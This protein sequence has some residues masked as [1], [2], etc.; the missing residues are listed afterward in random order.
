[1]GQD[2][3]FVKNWRGVVTLIGFAALAGGAIYY[4]DGFIAACA[5]LVG[6]IIRHE[7]A[8]RNKPSNS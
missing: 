3:E 4:Q 1:M 2:D 5:L 8:Q 6:L 7:L